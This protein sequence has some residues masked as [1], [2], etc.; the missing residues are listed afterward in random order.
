MSAKATQTQPVPCSN[1]GRKL[2]AA[3]SIAAGKGRTCT[4]KLRDAARAK[5]TAGVKP[6]LVAKAVELIADN[7][8]VQI[9]PT[10]F[11]SMS[12][13]GTRAYLTAPQGCTCPAGVR[14]KYLCYHRV[15]AAIAL[16]A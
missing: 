9:R 8:L 1:C 3:R 14:G 4:R 11:K 5:A 13:D 2:T 7:G 10:V 15:A 16:A 12:S 6:E